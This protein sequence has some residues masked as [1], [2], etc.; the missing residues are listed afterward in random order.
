MGHESRPREAEGP[1]LLASHNTISSSG[2]RKDQRWESHRDEIY[3]IYMLRNNTLKKT[4][5][6]IQEKYGFSPR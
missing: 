6:I 2:R 4:M 1:E 3:E 5:Q